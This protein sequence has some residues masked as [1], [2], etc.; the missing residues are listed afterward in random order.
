ML[1]CLY[2]E[3]RDALWPERELLGS[4]GIRVEGLSASDRFAAR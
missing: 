3:M 2:G 4:E 1:I